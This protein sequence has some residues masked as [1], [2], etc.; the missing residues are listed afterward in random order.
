MAK[1][2]CFTFIPYQSNQLE[3]FGYWEHGML[4]CKSTSAL[5]A[6]LLIQTESSSAAAA[7]SSPSSHVNKAL[8]CFLITIRCVEV[9][10][11]T[12]A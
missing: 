10:L 11:C 3:Y 7:I 1:R 6:R 8:H 12:A 4:H 9:M 5:K 2:S